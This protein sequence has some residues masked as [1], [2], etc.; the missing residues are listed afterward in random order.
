MVPFLRLHLPILQNEIMHF[1]R[2]AKLTPAQYIRQHE[3]L[4]LDTP[5]ALSLSNNNANSFA[6]SGAHLSNNASSSLASV[7]EPFDIFQPTHEHLMGVKESAKRRLSPDPRK[8]NLS[9]KN[10]EDKDSSSAGHP[11]P[12]K[13]HH[14]LAMSSLPSRIN[15]GLTPALL[16][17]PVLPNNGPP[18]NQQQQHSHGPSILHSHLA[19]QSRAALLEAESRERERERESQPAPSFNA[20]NGNTGREQLT[21]GGRTHAPSAS[22]YER[23]RY[24]NERYEKEFFSRPGPTMFYS[25]LQRSYSEEVSR[26]MEEE[27]KNIHTVSFSPVMPYQ[28]T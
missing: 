3:N 28:R 12:A 9:F 15:A 18:P 24:V 25:E 16:H 4:I 6:G 27:W 5:G 7:G 26:D 23:E 22:D 2:L 14:P 13:R 1:A 19:S 20:N 17:T 11:P 21:N 8:E 10:V